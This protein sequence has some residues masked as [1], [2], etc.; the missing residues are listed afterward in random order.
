[1]RVCLALSLFLAG[2]VG[3]AAALDRDGAIEAAKRQVRGKCTPEAPCTFTARAERDKWF[4][5]VEYTG[6][7]AIFIFNQAGKVLGRIEGK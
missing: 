6:G 5:R 7:H 3:S 4:V 2:W 1:M